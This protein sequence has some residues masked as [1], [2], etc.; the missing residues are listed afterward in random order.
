MIKKIIQKQFKD[1]VGKENFINDR[2]ELLCFSYDAYVKKAMPDAV[3]YPQNTKEVSEILKIANCEE[4][5]VIPRGAGTNLSGGVIPI[6]QGLV[7]CMT[8]MNKILQICVK[9]RYAVVQPGVINGDLQKRLEEER[10][11]YPPDPASF[12][13]STIGGNVSENSGGPRCL[14]Y[15]VTADYILGLEVV[16]PSGEIIHT[17]SKNIKDVAG[18]KLSGLFCGSEGT[19]GILTEI[20]LKIVPLPKAY[21][22]ILAIYN[23]LDQTANTVA[24]VIGSGILPSAMELM[25]KSVINVIEDNAQMGLPRE[26][27][28][29]LLIEVD[30]LEDVIEGQ[31]KIIIEKV[32]DN[33][34][35]KIIEAKNQ[36]ERDDLWK[37]RR[38]AYGAYARLAPNCISEDVTV[39][40]SKVPI[41]VRGIKRIA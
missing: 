40:V 38:S 14:K 1:I 20:I 24:D 17:G 5:P 3:I 15:G 25:D 31:M 13:V 28:G 37:A 8:K 11:F 4:I 22:T 6:R 32:K 21:K 36:A 2:E 30:G 27:A 23:D 29:V 39:P 12:T 10:F 7:L 35:I 9:D 33:G 26:A 41:M 19:L 16:L 18:Y 34:A